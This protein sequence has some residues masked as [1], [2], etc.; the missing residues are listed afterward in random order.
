MTDEGET[1]IH[2][3]LPIPDP[4]DEEKMRQSKREVLEAA[5]AQ[6]QDLMNDEPGPNYDGPTWPSDATPMLLL[7]WAPDDTLRCVV[8]HD[9]DP[10]LSPAAWPLERELTSLREDPP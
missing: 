1:V 7:L 10:D 2:V 3:D 4:Y 8:R 9:E 5:E 6:A